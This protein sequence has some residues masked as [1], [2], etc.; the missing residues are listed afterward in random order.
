MKTTLQM[1][2]IT[3]L[4][5][6]DPSLGRQWDAVSYAVLALG[7][8][9]L[10]SGVCFALLGLPQS[11]SHDQW[12]FLGQQAEYGTAFAAWRQYEHHRLVVPGLLLALDQMIAG[13][14]NWVVLA[15]TMGAQL[16]L[17][18]VFARLCQARDLV[19]PADRRMLVGLLCVAALLSGHID[20]YVIP[21][22]SWASLTVFFAVLSTIFLDRAVRHEGTSRFIVPMGFSLAS[23]VVAT[24]SGAPGILVW[25]TV[26]LLAIAARARLT[27]MLFLLTGGVAISIVYYSGY[28]FSVY[29]PGGL[30]LFASPE[31]ILLSFCYYLGAPLV[32]PLL[33]ESL[34]PIGISIAVFIGGIG[35][36]GSA[37]LVSLRL[38]TLRLETTLDSA[39]FGAIVFSLGWA[40]AIVIKHTQAPPLP[41]NLV[42]SSAYMLSVM[43]FWAT[44]IFQSIR[45]LGRRQ[46]SN[47]VRKAL[48]TGCALVILG[49]V[50]THLYVGARAIVVRQIV[51]FSALAAIAGVV[52]SELSR[53]SPS[54]SVVPTGSTIRVI[55]WLKRNQ[56]PPLDSLPAR[57]VGRPVTILGPLP[58]AR[59]DGSILGRRR[60]QDPPGFRLWGRWASLDPDRRVVILDSD[61][62]ITGLGKRWR[63]PLYRRW[64]ALPGVAVQDGWL[65]YTPMSWRE[66]YR[67][68]G[69]AKDDKPECLFA[70][71]EPS[72]AAG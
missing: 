54:G 20:V 12:F 30:Q 42:L 7:G 21:Y 15:L 59:C 33:I 35:L 28:N 31:R 58:K 19:G 62:T 55:G 5:S 68:V 66:P 63:A 71:F 29:G 65:A 8:L 27:T 22:L 2:G 17:V 40:A 23:A 10:A 6:R 3:K 57:A 16:I 67:V 38:T 34:A 53:Q 36:L 52:D 14:R 70:P 1:V 4:I 45:L 11:P 56:L 44:L 39:C 26:L 61:N 49:L 50:P 32:R 24:L 9:I 13:G 48:F 43:W 64:L 69:I 18:V 37:V 25:P 41:W 60:L 47:A 46:A 72:R 51:E